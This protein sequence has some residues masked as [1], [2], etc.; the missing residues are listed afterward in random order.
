MKK[1]VRNSV[2]AAFL[3][4]AAAVWQPRIAYADGLC[5]SAS[6]AEDQIDEMNQDIVDRF[7]ELLEQEQNFIDLKLMDAAKQEVMAR[8]AEFGDNYAKGLGEFWRD[9]NENNDPDPKG[10]YEQLKLMTTQLNMAK[11]QQTMQLGAQIDAEV[12]Q[13]A[14]LQ[15]QQQEIK[16]QQVMTTSQQ[17][18]Q[19]DTV[20]PQMGAASVKTRAIARGFALDNQKRTMNAAPSGP[21]PATPGLYRDQHNLAKA[22]AKGPIYEQA[23]LYDEYKQYFCDPAAG[24]AGCTT[25]GSLAGQNTDLPALLWGDK[26]SADLGQSATGE[27][28]RRVRAAVLRT[29]ISPRSP[30]PVPPEITDSTTGQQELLRRRAHAARINSIYNVVAQMMAERVSVTSF[31]P[32][33]SPADIRTASGVAPGDSTVNPS[34]REIQEA[35]SRDRFIHPEY[36]AQLIG[37]PWEIAREEVGV[38]ATRMQQMSDLYKRT[39]EM[40]FMEAAVY[41]EDLDKMMPTDGIEQTKVRK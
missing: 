9:N 26:Q 23:V 41:G 19:L 3:F 18:C 36:T 29:L 17:G 33:V 15:Q 31:A 37:A 30:A 20:G 34:Y 8:L 32:D 12:T 35:M 4:T 40:V 10:L 5:E 14:A 25:A 16:A 24:D 38:N 27:N 22:A 39:E 28:N 2:L 11:V 21:A 13:E 1:I 7:N 6:D